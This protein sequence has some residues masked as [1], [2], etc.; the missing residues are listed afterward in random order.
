MAAQFDEAKLRWGVATALR[1]AVVVIAFISVFTIV[2]LEWL[3]VLAPI[4]TTAS[5]LLQ[6]WADSF[7]GKAEK[8]KHRLEYYDGLGWEIPQREVDDQIVEASKRVRNKAYRPEESPY[9]DSIEVPSPKRVVDNLEQSAW[10]TQHLSKKMATIVFVASGFAVAAVFIVLVVVLQS[11]RLQQWGPNV[12]R[13][14]ITALVFMASYNYVRL[15]FQ[16][17][18][19]SRQSGQICNVVSHLR[20]LPAI[21]DVQAIT[22][23]HEYHIARVKAPMIPNFIWNKMEPELNRRWKKRLRV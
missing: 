7:R 12:G 14:A 4:C 5:A 13:I 21:T 19:L 16:Y 1:F 15:G 10:F 23:L 6:W 9:F 20:K 3:W 17:F 18:S 8:L 2:W 22:L 11:L